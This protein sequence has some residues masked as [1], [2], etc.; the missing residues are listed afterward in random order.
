MLDVAVLPL[1]FAVAFPLLRAVLKKHI[2]QVNQITGQAFA[3]QFPQV[4]ASLGCEVLRH[5][6]RRFGI[7][8]LN[9]G[10]SCQG[11]GTVT[12]QA[13]ILTRPAAKVPA[14][15]TPSD[16]DAAAVPRTQG[17]QAWMLVG[18]KVPAKCAC[19]CAQFPCRLPLCPGL[20]LQ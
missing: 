9:A 6:S 13:A 15:A 5:K 14:T 19:T 4:M 10:P 7:C 12:A 8:I 20:P 3:Q 17:Q 18:G 11:G 16:L 2:Y 1:F